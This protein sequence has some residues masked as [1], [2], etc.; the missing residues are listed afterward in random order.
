MAQFWPKVV[1]SG[2]RSESANC[3]RA[4]PSC[5]RARPNLGR[6]RP[7]GDRPP[8]CP[9]DR[10]RSGHLII[11]AISGLYRDA[12]IM[13]PDRPFC[14]ELL[15]AL[16]PNFGRK[17]SIPGRDRPEVLHIGRVRRNLSRV[18]RKFG[19]SKPKSGDRGPWKYMCYGTLIAQRRIVVLAPALRGRCSIGRAFCSACCAYLSSFCAL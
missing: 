7:S 13:T 3:C 11:S 1:D 6:A 14:G 8:C 17:W 15:W 19:R 18:R 4:R 5:C 2:P 9:S 12:A 10:L 16:W